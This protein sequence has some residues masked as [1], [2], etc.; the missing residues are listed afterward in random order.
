MMKDQLIL[1]GARAESYIKDHL[2]QKLD[3]DTICRALSTN[4][5]TLSRALIL[6][7]GRTLRRFIL[8]ERISM[9][10]TLLLSGE[11]NMHI[12]AEKCGFE[13]MYYFSNCFKSITKVSPSAYRRSN[14]H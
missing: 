4:R 5:T 9:S 3:R 2:S 13:N 14:N 12:I 7:T 6:R 10:K 1:L 8:D 11:Q